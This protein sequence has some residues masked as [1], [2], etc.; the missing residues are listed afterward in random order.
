MKPWPPVR[1][2]MPGA[3]AAG[4]SPPACRGARPL[5]TAAQNS[6][7]DM[8][9]SRARASALALASSVTFRW[10]REGSAEKRR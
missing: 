9:R 6:L 10:L 2:A 8:P 3:Y 7:S 1:P 5:I 4:L